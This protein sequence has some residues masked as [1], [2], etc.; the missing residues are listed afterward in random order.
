MGLYGAQLAQ[1]TNGILPSYSTALSVEEN[2]TFALPSFCLLSPG[3]RIGFCRGP[4]SERRAIGSDKTDQK[5][6][7]Q[8]ALSWL[9]KEFLRDG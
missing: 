1:R 6:H 8:G 5:L 9:K 2:D 4:M 7:Y 3:N